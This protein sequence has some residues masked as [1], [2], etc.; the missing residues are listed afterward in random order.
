N[1]VYACLDALTL[2]QYSD[3]PVGA[4]Y[5]TGYCNSTI[6]VTSLISCADTYCTPEQIDAG[7]KVENGYCVNYGF[8]SLPSI[9][10]ARAKVPG[11]VETVDT[12]SMTGQMYNGT[13]VPSQEAFAAGYKTENV[14]G[15]ESIFHQAFGWTMYLL[16]G[17]AIVVGMINRV[18][19]WF[20]NKYPLH[21]DEIESKQGWAGKMYTYY[22]KYFGVPAL[23]G[24]RR[25]QPWGWFSIPTRLQGFWV[26]A[27]VIINIVFC[28]VD[29]N[30]FEENLYWPHQIAV[31][32]WRYVSDRTAII[33]F[34]NLPLLWCLAGRNDVFLWLTG[35]SYATMNLFHRW[36]ARMATV[37]ALVHSA[38]WTWLY[39]SFYGNYAAQYKD[40]W[41]TA[42]VVAMVTM[43][44]I[45][46]LSILPLRH[47]MYEFFLLIHIALA[48]ATLVL[49]WYH[50]Q[51]YDGAYNGFIWAC[52]AV[53]CFDRAVR[54]VRVFVLS[55]K[56]FKAGGFN[57]MG[58]MT[59][60]Q[61]HGLIRLDVTTSINLTPRPGQHYFLYTPRLFNFWENHPF[62][63]ASWNQIDG[64]THLHFM[65]APQRGATRQLQRKLR[66]TE[67]GSVMLRVLIEGPYGSTHNLRGFDT[68]LLIAGGSGIT[69]V[70]PYL[71][72][73]HLA[74]CSSTSHVRR[75]ILIWAVK[76]ME[77]A[78]NVLKHEL[79]EVSSM[80]EV[81][82]YTTSKDE[83]AIQALP[84]SD[85]S[86]SSDEIVRSSMGENAEKVGEGKGTRRSTIKYGRPLL[87]EIL[88]EG[89][90]KS[91][92]RV[93]VMACGPN[94]MMDDMRK[95]VAHAYG[96]KRG[97]V[98]GSR[99]EYFEE[100]FA[101]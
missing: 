39:V 6:F 45:L 26:F 89:L 31:Q 68:V 69:A 1:C 98:S 92:G 93:A 57:T 22:R 55:F 95:I 23:F 75:I 52:V 91:H 80:T 53:W 7:W 87:K 101:W 19:A 76:D 59:G 15:K 46:P 17:S 16:F 56:T 73:L 88:D 3:I 62:T 74:D 44:L 28:T 40:L 86:S 37:Q 64:H 10:E 85:S 36:V 54:L 42:G 58:T 11:N 79:S 96:T 100:Q 97:K 27:Y 13:I 90:M 50:V 94:Q 78:S 2:V 33:C 66:R 63:L 47:K 9:E 84:E 77:Y 30:L 14:W 29:Y 83:S 4:S 82:I 81:N 18:Y 70:L 8:V 35:W 34:Y 51:V 61:Q 20:V 67:N 41:W 12:L 43:A 25:A 99:M 5:Y 38:A 60:S 21:E 71:H 65:V 72:D 32:R 24:Y 48:L 49:L